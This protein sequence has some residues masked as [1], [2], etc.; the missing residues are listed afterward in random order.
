[1]KKEKAYVTESGEYRVKRIK[2]LDVVALVMSILIAFII[3]LYAISTNSPIYESSIKSINVSV[4]NIPTGLSVISGLDHTVNLKVKGKRSDVLAL[5]ESDIKAYVDASGCVESDNHQYELDVNVNLPSG[6]TLSEIYPQKVIVYLDNTT[7]KSL[8]IKINLRN[9]TID[10]NCTL[11]K[12]TP[13]L[14]T[15]TIKG[16]ADE[17]NKI[18]E[19]RVT[20]EPGYINTSMTASGS[21]LLYDYEGNLYSNPYVTCSVSDVLVRIDVHKYKTVP[22]KVA[23]KYGYYN[24]NNVTVSVEPSEVRIKGAAEVIDD[25]NSII[26]AT[27][28]ETE[29]MSDGKVVYELELPNGITTQQDIENVVVNIT[30]KNTEV[31]TLSV[32]NIRLDNGEDGRTYEFMHDSVNVTIRGTAGEYFTQF[33]EENITVVLNMKNYKNIY[34]N[35]TV[36]AQIEINNPSSDTLI[37]ALGSYS[38]NL[39]IY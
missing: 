10:S 21:V 30:H 15:V 1:M 39:V 12:S 37:Y 14:S 26:I 11:E 7:S 2:W 31:K 4:E 27:I 38:V 3:W 19:A 35:V 13:D 24:D 25:I 5:T 29:V 20:I 36:P 9:Y 23:Y 33:D 28:D 8:P 6:I 18:E 16:P 32:R 22:L 34:G 17:L